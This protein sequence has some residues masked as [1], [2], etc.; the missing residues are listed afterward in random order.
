[1]NKYEYN[2]YEQISR[3]IKKYRKEAGMTQAVLSEKVG[4]S[5]EFIRRIESKKGVKTFSVDTVWKI[6]L[7]NA[8]ITEIMHVV[9]KRS[10]ITMQ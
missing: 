6:K 10:L 4:L 7:T 5:H 9:S 2:I 8:K 1:M 3:N